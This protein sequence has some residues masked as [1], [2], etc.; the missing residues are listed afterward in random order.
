[1][2]QKIEKLEEL[3]IGV[4]N[5]SYILTGITG[6]KLIKKLNEL[7]DSHNS[8]AGEEG[9]VPIHNSNDYCVGIGCEKYPYKH[10]GHK[11]VT[12]ESKQDTREEN[13]S[14]VQPIG[15]LTPEQMKEIFPKQDLKEHT[16]EKCCHIL[17]FSKR[18]EDEISYQCQKCGD[19]VDIVIAPSHPQVE[20][21]EIDVEA[22]L[23]KQIRILETTLGFMSSR[24][25]DN[26]TRE[27][28]KQLTLIKIKSRAITP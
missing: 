2:K 24:E 27:V 23:E 25:A 21:E 7:I 28:I 15:H 3:P 9:E 19:Q 17:G 4:I 12:E 6:N 26:V 14:T 8:L 16:Q 13:R 10:T 22:L 18:S 20:K 5:Q 1:M 11:I